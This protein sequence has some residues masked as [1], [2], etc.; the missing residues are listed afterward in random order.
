VDPLGALADFVLGKLKQSAMALWLKL[1]FTMSFSAVVSFL[2]VAG[3]ILALGQP[4]GFAVG[5]G[6]MMAAMA[7]TVLFRRSPLTNR[8]MVVLPQAEAA[9]ELE[10]NFQTIEKSK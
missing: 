3:T 6:M 5:S 9:R 8:L 1:L 4:A 10:T 2:F 7:M